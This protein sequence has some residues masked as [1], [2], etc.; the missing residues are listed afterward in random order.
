MRVLILDQRKD[1]RL[2]CFFHFGTY[3]A[4]ITRA[5]KTERHT[6]SAKEDHDI[7]AGNYEAYRIHVAERLSSR[8]PESH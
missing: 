3:L 8:L 4:G 7:S 2:T 1:G 5:G 6:K